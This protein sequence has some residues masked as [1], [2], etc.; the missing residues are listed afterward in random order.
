MQWRWLFGSKVDVSIFWL[1]I[2][3]GI[4]AFAGTQTSAFFQSVIFSIIIADAFEAGPFHQGPTLFAYFDKRNREHW[5]AD[6][7][8]RRIFFFAPPLI[9]LISTVMFVLCKELVILVWMLWAMQ[10]FIQQN[11]GILLLYHN[12]NQGEAVIARSLETRSQWAACSLFFAMFWQRVM[13]KGEP[14]VISQAAIVIAACAALFYCT[15]YVFE[16]VRQVRGGA[17]LNMPATLFWLFSI[18][19]FVPLAFIGQ[20]F[21]DAYLIPTTVHFFQYIGLNFV[22]AKNKYRGELS[23]NLTMSNPILLLTM[24]CVLTVAIN[25]FLNLE[26]KDTLIDAHLRDA[27][28]GAGLGIAFCHFFLDA[29]MWRFRDQFQRSTILPYLKA[30]N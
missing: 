4:L 20:S 3:V 26:S 10:H 21:Y 1:P 16:L 24:V 8:L 29:F 18:F 19:A 30:R 25:L 2:L 13:Q 17:Y 6:E 5:G 15:K 12:H 14:T 28:K 11:I 22:L 7:K 9:I 23:S 27:A